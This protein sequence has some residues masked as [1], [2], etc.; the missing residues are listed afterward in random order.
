MNMHRLVA[1]TVARDLAGDTYLVADLREFQG[2]GDFAAAFGLQAGGGRRAF[3]LA[4]RC[5]R[6]EHCRN[7]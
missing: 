3:R 4:Q 5:A 2:A 1:G 7:R 6:G